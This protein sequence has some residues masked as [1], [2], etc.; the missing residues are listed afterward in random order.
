MSTVLMEPNTELQLSQDNES[1][2]RESSS[3]LTEDIPCKKEEKMN[4][5][6]NLPQKN[7]KMQRRYDFKTVNGREKRKKT[8][9]L[10]LN[11]KK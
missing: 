7:K 11:K 9:T 6:T 5:A 2:L 10:F 4:T 8:K 3:K 1:A